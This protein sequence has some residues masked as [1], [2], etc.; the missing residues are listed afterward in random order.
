MKKKMSYLN[1]AV[2]EIDFRK[3][4]IKTMKII[5]R[6]FLRLVKI[7]VHKILLILGVAIIVSDWRNYSSEN[8]HIYIFTDLESMLFS[9]VS[10]LYKL[11][12]DCHC[13]S[14]SWRSFSNLHGLLVQGLRSQILQVCRCTFNYFYEYYW[15]VRNHAPKLLTGPNHWH[16]LQRS[17]G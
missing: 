11:R 3:N 16:L 10:E 12:L 6:K 2:L 15:C 14:H 13:N 17:F 1:L 9:M 8:I 4:W 7:P 5:V